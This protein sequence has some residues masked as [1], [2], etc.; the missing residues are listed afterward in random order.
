MKSLSVPTGSAA[1]TLTTE[2]RQQLARERN[3]GVARSFGSVGYTATGNRFR[4]LV[5]RRGRRKSVDV[6]RHCNEIVMVVTSR[7]NR[8]QAEQ[9]KSTD[10][11][12][13]EKRSRVEHFANGS[14]PQC[15]LRVRWRTGLLSNLDPNYRPFNSS[16]EFLATPKVGCQCH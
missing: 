2:N 11:E 7:T 12:P 13:V 6:M 4:L 10:L 9:I 14:E 16:S 3:F 8:F 1:P 15:L 5:G